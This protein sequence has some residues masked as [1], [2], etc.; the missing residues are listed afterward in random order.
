V[1]GEA[2]QHDRMQ[3]AIQ[4]TVAAP[5]ETVAHDLAGRG[6]TGVTPASAAKAAS[7]RIRPRCD[8]DTRICAAVIAPTPGC[9][10]SSG[11]KRLTSSST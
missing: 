11:A 3:S 10:K 2:R 8:Q 5:V 9:A 7:E 4:L 1:M 6:G